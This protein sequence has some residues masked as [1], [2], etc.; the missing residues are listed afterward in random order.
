MGYAIRN[1][2]QGW[3]A[4]DAPDDCTID[5]TFS[6]DQPQP[7][8]FQL[9][10]L[11]AI[12]AKKSKTAALNTITVTTSSGKV[13][14]GDDTAINRMTAAILT[15]E[16]I[17]QTSAEWTLADNTKVTVTLDEVRE[18]LALSIQRVG[19]IVTA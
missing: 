3:R 9:D 10:D 5:E 11:A 16:F 6:E 7:S 17:G 15:A 14:D 12:E 18:A 19:E 4:V 8:Q 1:D 2:G 13:F